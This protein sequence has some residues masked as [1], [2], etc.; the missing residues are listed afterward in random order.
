MK[1]SH[2]F[3]NAGL[4]AIGVWILILDAKTALEGAKEGIAVCIQTVVPC[5]FPFFV[6]SSLLT[7]NISGF[8]TKHLAWI[9]KI[10]GIPHGTELIWV[11]GLLGGYPIGAKCVHQAFESGSIDKNTARRMLGFCSNAGPAFIFGMTSIF[12]PGNIYPWLLFGIQ[13]LSSLITGV[14][15]PGRTP[16]TN[17]NMPVKNVT[18]NEALQNALRGICSVCGWIILFRVILGMS[19]RWFMWLIP[20]QAAVILTGLTELSNGILILEKITSVPERFILCSGLLN[21]GGFC[22][23]M[24]TGAVTGSLGFGAYFPGKFLQTA[25]SIFLASALCAALYGVGALYCLISL[26]VLLSFVLYFYEKKKKTVAIPEM[27]LYNG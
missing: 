24:Q 19:T 8:R 21:F 18:W 23:A 22:I 25:V 10:L 6:M 2:A 15:L 9:G 12:F 7:G 4:A 26:A 5:L 3:W 16:V 20:D 13:I 17:A 11:T 14:F 27:L 1:K